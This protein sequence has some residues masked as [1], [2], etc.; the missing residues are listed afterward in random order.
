[1]IRDVWLGIWSAFKGFGYGY[2]AWKYK[3]DF[4]RIKRWHRRTRWWM[5]PVRNAIT[6]WRLRNL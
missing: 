3:G 6:D 2:V 1:M 4:E 5:H